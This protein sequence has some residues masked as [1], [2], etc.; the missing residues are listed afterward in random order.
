MMVDERELDLSELR[1]P[2]QN[3]QSKKPGDLYDMWQGK[4]NPITLFD[5][6]VI[7]PDI[8]ASLGVDQLLGLSE[9]EELQQYFWEKG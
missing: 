1:P 3:P 2:E 8:I 5:S 6:T 7:T 4:M 9:K